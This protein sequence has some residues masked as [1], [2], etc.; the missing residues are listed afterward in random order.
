M[1]FTD[2]LNLNSGIVAFFTA[3]VLAIIIGMYVYLSRRQPKVPD[4]LEI[5]NIPEIVVFLR[6]HVAHTQHLMLCL[7]NVG[8]G[9][10]HDVQFTTNFPFSPDDGARKP[11]GV[12]PEIP[13]ILKSDDV[14]SVK[15]VHIFTKGLNCFGP[16]QKIEQFLVNL[17]GIFDE[18]KQTPLKINVTYKDLS[19]QKYDKTFDFDFS[20]F[21]S[22]VQIDATEK[23]G[24]AI[25]DLN[26]LLYDI[27]NITQAGLKILEHQFPSHIPAPHGPETRLQKEPEFSQSVRSEQ[28]EL[29]LQALQKFRDIYNAKVKDQ[30]GWMNFRNDHTFFR[31][32]VKNSDERRQNPNAFPIFKTD[33]AGKLFAFYIKSADLYAVVPN[34]GLVMEHLTYDLSAFSEVFEC[35]GFNYQNRYHIKVTQPARFEQ[36][37]G[38]ET[39]TL[40]QK[41]V[42]ELKTI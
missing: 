11:P 8:T 41:G 39:W 4:Q 22:L 9:A 28:D 25:L 35:P 10:A 16:G 24:Q 15:K 3:I 20:E 14:S 40:K 5:T 21:E 17:V 38:K 30:Q 29:T 33:S 23:V 13:S 26:S 2:W 6:P 37:R 42:L 27:K 12:Y 34:Y 7:E 19:G 36:D 32:G 18:L 31:I 1:E